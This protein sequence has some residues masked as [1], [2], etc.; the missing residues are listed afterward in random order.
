MLPT[1]KTILYLTDLSKN[2]AYV[3]RYAV[4][5][6]KTFQAK[7][8]ILHVIKNV[9]PAMEIPIIVRMGEEA[10]RHL[11]EER[12]QEIIIGIRERL[13]AFIQKELRE[14]PDQSCLVESIHV[15][16]GEPVAE[17]LETAER[18]DCDL[19]VMGDHSKGRLALTFL[20]STAEKVLRSSRR[21]VMVV[22]I[23]VKG[24]EN[25]STSAV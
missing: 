5:L 2:S 16:E 8:L 15:H 1:I 10:Y 14:D 23:P 18:F 25:E 20:G 17:I 6:A 12:E 9:D 22:P 3:F 7:I 21:P 19:L 24:S 11:V 13:K 4:Q